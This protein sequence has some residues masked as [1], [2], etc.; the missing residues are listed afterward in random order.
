VY[1]SIMKYIH[2]LCTV[3]L[4]TILMIPASLVALE[5]DFVPSSVGAGK[6]EL[7]I[8]SDKIM[9]VKSARVDRIV[10]TTMYLTMKWQDLPMHFTMKTNTKTTV[11]KRYGGF[12]E[13][14]N[15]KVGDY[16][17]AEGE[18]FIGSDFFGFTAQ[19]IK[20]WSLQEESATFSGK[21]VE[22]NSGSF[23]LQTPEKSITVVP[24]GA[25]TIT[26]GQVVIPWERIVKGDVVVLTDGVFDYPKNTLTTSN[27][28]IFHSKDDFTPRNFQGTLKVIEGENALIVSV[29]G[30]DYTVSLSSS[31]LIL[32]K[33]RSQAK[34]ARFV[35]GDTVRFYGAVLEKDNILSG[36]L[37]VPAEVVRNISL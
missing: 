32:R 19:K 26:K 35:V 16:I 27:I 2:T 14:A 1:Y 12:T 34:L 5:N 30:S 7:H 18:F 13:A 37:L 21:I 24:T 3:V 28:A 23:V 10:N 31:T 25:V 22:I 20:D 29:N 9:V 6:P 17:D 4:L 33:D 15:M 8:N 11:V 36:Q